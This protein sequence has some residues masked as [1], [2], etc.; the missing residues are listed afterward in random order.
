MTPGQAG[1]PDFSNSLISGALRVAAGG[2]TILEQC[3]GTMGGAGAAACTPGTRFQIASISRQFTAAAVLVLAQ[4]GALDP[5]DPLIR[6]FPGGPHGW[7]DITVHHLLCHTSGL[8]HWEDFP[9]IDIRAPV[10]G[11]DLRAAVREHPPVTGR[12][13][14]SAIPAASSRWV[15]SSTTRVRARAICTPPWVTWT[16]GTGRW[17]AGCSASRTAG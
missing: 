10:S 5:G 6:W 2:E 3:T 7:Q 13:S 16:G 15:T 1:L 4:R 9:E 14:R 8:G 11:R 12:T 17:R